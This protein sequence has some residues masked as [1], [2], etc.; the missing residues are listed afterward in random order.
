MRNL[1]L[2]TLKMKTLMLLLLFYCFS[3]TSS[4]QPIRNL[5]VDPTG[6][7][8]LKGENQKGEIRGNFGEIRVKLMND[9]T[10]AFTMYSNKGFPD[11]TYASFNDTVPYAN[12]KASYTSAKDTSCRL[13]FDFQSDGLT[14]KQIYS[15]PASTCGFGSGVIPLGFIEKYSSDIPVIQP[16]QRSR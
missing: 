8:L 5:V 7:Y 9:S 10:V 4:S 3:H 12:N 13:V 2:Q 1:L 16:I 6:T 14:I 15:D 11:Y